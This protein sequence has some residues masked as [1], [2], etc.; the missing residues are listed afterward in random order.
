MTD[1]HSGP[2][3]SSTDPLE[4]HLRSRIDTTF[5]GTVADLSSLVKIPSVSWDGFDAEHVA[6]SSEAVAELARSTGIFETVDVTSVAFEEGGSDH[7]HPAILARRPAR[8]GAPTVLLYAHH[9]VQPPGDPALWE[10]EAFV[11]TVRGDRLYGR[12]ASD[13]KAG[14]IT[15]IAA[16][17]ALAE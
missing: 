13:D 3:P 17:R 6:R 5:P 2:R 15:H 11:P 9:D 14:V 8:D 4:Q 16:L 12:G 1:S 10:S 7:G